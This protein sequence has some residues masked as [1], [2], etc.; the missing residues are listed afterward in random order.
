MRAKRAEASYLIARAYGTA[1]EL[2]ERLLAYEET[3]LDHPLSLFGRKSRLAIAALKKAHRKKLPK[4]K[5]TAAALLNR[6]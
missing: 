1:E 4:F 6:G 5:A 3:D 2:E